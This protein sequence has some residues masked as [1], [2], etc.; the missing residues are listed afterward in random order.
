[1]RP[2]PIREPVG[3]LD[4]LAS[5]IETSGY[6]TLVEVGVER[7]LFSEALLT[8]CPSLQVM[9]VDAW[10]P[11]AGY[12]VHVSA[13]KLAE[14][15]A[16]ARRRLSAFGGRVS[17]RKGWSVA[18]AAEMAPA[19]V[20]VVYIDANH[21]RPQVRADI[22]AWWPIVRPGGILAGHDFRRR[23]P[24]EH[25]QVVEAVTSWIAARSISPWYVLT[26]D[27]SPSWLV[28]KRG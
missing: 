23:Q 15:E 6:S 13:E 7:G 22:E 1:M 10:C 18:I 5:R 20:D 24:D 21:T 9:A 25:F 19:S 28:V 8:R 27:R 14:I 2:E 11:Y 16:D 17:I 4:G 12:R 3:R 26:G